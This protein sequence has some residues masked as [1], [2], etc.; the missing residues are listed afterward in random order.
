MQLAQGDRMFTRDPLERDFVECLSVNPHRFGSEILG[1]A[2]TF[3]LWKMLSRSAG[4]S[5]AAVETATPVGGHRIVAFGADV[6]VSNAFVDAEL[7]NPRPFLNSRVLESVAQ[8]RSV[9]LSREQIR[10]A[11]STGGLDAVILYG[12]WRRDLL[13]PEEVSEVCTLLAT[14]YLQ[15]RVGYR[16]NR[17]L[18]EVVNEELSVCLAMRTWREVRRFDRLH[19]NRSLLV[20]TR[21]DSFAVPA[22]LSNP[23]FHFREPVLRLRDA[24]QELLLAALD[25]LTDEELASKLRLTLPA[26]KKRWL[27]VFE[28]TVHTRPDLFPEVD[29]SQE[30]GKRSGQKRHHIL[31]YVRSHLEELRPRIAT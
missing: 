2:R 28:R 19:T 15:V 30:D 6:F 31:A 3:E 7:A 5:A 22:S 26:I 11:N 20:M 13:A 23:L 1:Q 18:M 12:S 21:E 25:G 24:D 4:W 8:G 16:L 10:E 14:R 17:L 27:S 9:A 29:R